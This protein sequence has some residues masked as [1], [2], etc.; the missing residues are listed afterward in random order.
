MSLR[1]IKMFLCV[2]LLSGLPALCGV[3]QGQVNDQPDLELVVGDRVMVVATKTEIHRNKHQPESLAGGHVSRVRGLQGDRVMINGNSFEGLVSRQDVMLLS[4]AVGLF[5]TRLREHPDDHQSRLAYGICLEYADLPSAIAEFDQV[6]REAPDE[7]MAWAHRGFCRARRGDSADEFES[8][9][10]EALRLA[11][12]DSQILAL[13]ADSLHRRKKSGEAWLVAQETH[14]LA[15][16]DPYVATIASSIAF[17]LKDYNAVRR[18]TTEALKVH[19]SMDTLL[20]RRAAA[21]MQELRD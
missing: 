10:A 19:P 8:D 3:V 12:G 4:K 5:E 16:F 20:T 13:K 18:I 17:S 14:K 2:L 21:D 6:I 15:P 1:R 11:P 9:F 7:A